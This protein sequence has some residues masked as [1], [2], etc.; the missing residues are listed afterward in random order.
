MMRLAC[1]WKVVDRVPRVK[2]LRGE[3]NRE[4]ILPHDREAVY[5]AALPHPLS[6]AATVLLDTGLRLGELLSLDWAQVH[7]APAKGASYGYLTILSG[8]AKKQEVL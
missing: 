3:K 8:K 5:L 7:I 6:D 4:S 2:L 1:E